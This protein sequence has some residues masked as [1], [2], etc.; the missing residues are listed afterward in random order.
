MRFVAALSGAILLWCGAVAQAADDA[1]A[2][3]APPIPKEWL[4]KRISVA[5]AEAAFP[6]ITDDRVAQYPEAA[7]PFGFE[8]REWEALKTQMRPGDELWTYASPADSWL[9]L[10]GRAGIALVRDGTPIAALLGAMN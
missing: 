7:K 8:S 9:H 2:S 3:A 4:Q 6:G 5:E 1:P 10:A